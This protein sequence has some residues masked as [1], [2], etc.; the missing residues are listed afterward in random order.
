MLLVSPQIADEDVP[1][2]VDKVT[3]FVT[4]HGGSVAEVKPWGRRKMAYHIQDF[5]EANYVVTNFSMDPKNAVELEA[6]LNISEDLIRH[7][8]TRPPKP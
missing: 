8:L 1:A 4:E 3:S 2:I 5:Q 6:S 7:L